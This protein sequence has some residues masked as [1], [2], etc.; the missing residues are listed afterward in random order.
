[1]IC[2]CR[3]VAFLMIG[4]GLSL[5]AA[6]YVAPSYVK[7]PSW[8]QGLIQTRERVRQYE[9]WRRETATELKL[10][11]LTL[12]RS[13]FAAYPL[14]S[15]WALHDGFEIEKW[16]MQDG[17]PVAE[18][19]VIR[20]VLD[21][22]GARA[23]VFRASL[24]ALE[25]AEAD[26]NDPR[27]L[28]LYL[29]A[30]RA[31]RDQRLAYVREQAPDIVFIKRRPVS[32]SFFAYT[33]GQS[34][35]QHERHFS[36]GTALCLLHLRPDGVEVETLISSPKGVIRDADVSYDGKRILFAWKQADRTDDYHLY[37]LDVDNG[38]PRQ[39]T[40]G[41]G[42]AD[43]E[44]VYLPNDH[45]VFSSTRCVQ[46][47]DCWWTEVSNMYTCDGEGKFLRRLGFDQVHTISPKVLADGSVLYTRWDYNDRGQVYPQGLFR[48]NA[49]GTGQTEFYGNNSYFPTTTSHARGI[50]GTT[51]VVAVAMGHHTWQAGK[52]IE[53][54]PA[55]G[56]QEAEGVHYLAPRQPAK[57][58]RVDRFGQN[59]ELFRH[60][61]PL[62]NDQ[63]L[64]AYVPAVMNRGRSSVFGL[65][66]MDAAG[67]RELLAYDPS[68]SANH[69]IPLRPRPRPHLRPSTVDYRKNTGT[70]YVQDVYHGPG[71]K[72]IAR[73]TI[74]RLRVVAL[75]FRAAGIKNNGNRGPAGG[76][77]VS[78][79]IAVPN[80]AWDVK[81]V[82]GDATVYADG[83]AF[84]EAPARTPLYFQALDKAGNAV[85]TMRS[86]STLQP[87]EVF[88]CVGCHEHKNEA[89]PSA[90][91]LS[92]AMRLGPG[93]LT[94]FY[95]A[96]RGF[97]F[98]REIQ[99]ILD[100][101][102]IRCH[103]PSRMSGGNVVPTASRCW[104]NDRT[105]AICDG[106]IPKNSDDHA[107]P[108]HTWW[109][110]KGG[111]EWVQLTFAKP[112]NIGIVEVYWFDDRPRGG[113]CRI[114]ESWRLKYLDGETWQDVREASTYGVGRDTFNPTCF[115]PVTTT[116]LRVEARM[117]KGYSG[118]V[119]ELR[120]GATEE[121]LKTKPV[122][123]LDLTGTT[124][125]GTGGRQW[126]RSYL[127]LTNN[128]NSNRLVNWIS[129][130]SVPSMLP[131]YHKGAAT[132]GLISMLRN[133]HKDIVLAKA[134]IDRLACWIDLLVPYCGDYAEANAWSDDD[135]VKY[136]RYL[137]K[138]RRMEALERRNIEEF[139]QHVTGGRDRRP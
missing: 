99:P 56:R 104:R 83:S 47:V 39:L 68:I 117:R 74:E 45:I 73:G 37:E 130:Q 28:D 23:S 125:A 90:H 114:P 2:K 76:A 35:A 19:A 50:P 100:R 46:T 112:K 58:V 127:A 111:D 72:G 119:L 64:V 98:T 31:R 82:I 131:P 4:T 38:K 32:P 22:L 116:A 79:P 70:Y 93:K 120:C 139:V 75:E 49:D 54:D 137:N 61:Y 18:S 6:E 132:S 55:L 67:R 121:E 53:I 129:A 7:G 133:G 34:D 15:D 77:L 13:S 102:C 44:G 21:E 40:F 43:Y 59:G 48:M 97:S 10:D 78:T 25:K 3:C 107:I 123:A 106:A 57:A 42:F 20:R 89:P 30:C 1:M 128:G 115:A 92:I 113:G 101:H 69:P 12:L 109:S 24:N 138:R 96:P 62:G 27:W 81:R 8:A 88:S 16:L 122:V 11:T 14:E 103:N 26:T 118:G 66:C 124:M 36:P 52:L 5:P 51:K 87:G 134:E 126:S 91:A 94:P 9:A 80:G 135:K 60:P 86:W 108:R 136:A 29:R 110:R 17:Q 95:G 65:Y 84:F 41:L 85:Q 105:S 33:E 63:F 71:L